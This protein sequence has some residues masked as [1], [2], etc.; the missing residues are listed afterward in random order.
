MT[1][2]SDAPKPAFT[3]A[4][5]AWLGI[6]ALVVLARIP[7]LVGDGWSWFAT[8]S[9]RVVR[10]F[11]VPDAVLV[12]RATGLS[13]ALVGAI[14]EAAGQ[15]G[16]LVVFSP[17]GGQEFALDV[18]D[19]R[20][21]LARQTHQTFVRV[22]NLLYPRPRDVSVA[23][24]PDELVAKLAEPM[25]PG[26]AL[27]VLDGTQGPAPLAAPGEWELLHR[28]VLGGVG[29]LRLWRLRRRP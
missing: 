18:G 24:A 19:P 13:P 17:Y 2:S 8:C 15:E 23:F 16:R 27:L 20:G 14:R 7:F 10:G 29:Q 28:Q 11:T 12:Q 4:A 6:V 3:P 5:L 1:A 26:R 25:A 22:K 21:E 9:E